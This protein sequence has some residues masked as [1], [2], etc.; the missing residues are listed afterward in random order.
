M[1]KRSSDESRRRWCGN[2]Y[3]QIHWGHKSR[4]PEAGLFPATRC[5]ACPRNQSEHAP[6]C[7]ILSC[8]GAAHSSWKYSDLTRYLLSRQAALVS[9]PQASWLWV[10]PSRLR[11]IMR[12]KIRAT[13]QSH[14]GGLDFESSG[15]GA[16]WF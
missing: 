10:V 4:H 7:G 6:T 3:V 9:E 12:A 1:G 13:T 11:Q 14:T 15:G 8:L 16:G 5:L 2:G